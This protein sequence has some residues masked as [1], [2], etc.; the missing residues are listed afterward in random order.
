MPLCGRI[1]FLTISRAQRSAYIF[2][3]KISHAPVYSNA[4]GKLRQL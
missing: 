3:P 2:A 4:D 1:L